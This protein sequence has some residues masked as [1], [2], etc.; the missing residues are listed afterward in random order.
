MKFSVNPSNDVRVDFSEEVT[1]GAK[2]LD[3]V[4]PG[5]HNS[6]ELNTLDIESSY[7]CV[8]GQVG[9]QVVTKLAED[10]SESAAALLHAE[11]LVSAPGFDLVTAAKVEEG[12]GWAYRHGFNI[13]SDSIYDYCWDD[14]LET[15]KYD[16][17]DYWQMLTEEWV[18]LV[19]I[20]RAIEAGLK[21]E[22]TAMAAYAQELSE[23]LVPA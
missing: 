4:M 12:W 13:D 6:I 16:V 17:P 15:D 1:R 11:E 20:R 21:P 3:T 18:A 8:L 9:R 19:T 2:W 22:D 23:V 7:A 10:G 5:W 14:E